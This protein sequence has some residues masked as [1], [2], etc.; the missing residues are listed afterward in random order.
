MNTDHQPVAGFLDLEWLR[1]GVQPAD[2]STPEHKAVDVADRILNESLDMARNVIGHSPALRCQ[3]LALASAHAQV[4]AT[5][6]AAHLTAAA[7]DRNTAAINAPAEIQHVASLKRQIEAANRACCELGNAAGDAYDAAALAL[8]GFATDGA[9]LSP[10]KT[11]E[12]HAL[13]ELFESKRGAALDAEMQEKDALLE[14]LLFL[15]HP[16]L[17]SQPQTF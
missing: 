2:S 12:I 17:S 14:L 16:V 13:F 6:Y 7:P 15:K 11:R 1:L 3:V 9:G 5:V 8:A 4:A 10:E